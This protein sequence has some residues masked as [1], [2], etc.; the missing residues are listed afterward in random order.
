MTT[1]QT[2]VYVGID[3][4]KTQLEIAVRP[5]GPQTWQGRQHRGR[6]SATGGATKDPPVP[7]RYCHGSQRR[8]PDGVRRAGSRAAKLPGLGDQ[9]PAKRGYFAKSLGKLAKTDRIDARYSGSFRRSG[10]SRAATTAR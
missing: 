7:Q 1:K 5:S 3:V 2:C 10:S 9:P 6:H 8:V 4:S